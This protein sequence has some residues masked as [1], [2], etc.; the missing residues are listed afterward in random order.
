M[1]KAYDR[2]SL[3]TCAVTRRSGG[4][5]EE[6]TRD[7]LVRGHAYSIT[8]VQHIR[9]RNTVVHLVRVRNPWGDHYEW[10]GAWSDRL[11]SYYNSWQ[12]NS[13]KI[14][15]LY[16]VLLKRS[17]EWNMVDSATKAALGV[18][19]EHD[20]EF[21]MSIHD[22]QR[23][24]SRV[25]ICHISP[26][27]IDSDINKLFKKPWNKEIVEGEWIPGYSAGGCFNYSK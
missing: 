5:Y 12:K 2:S 7:G 13:I 11:V 18:T 14:K 24:F 10:N 20:G 19:H 15:V 16:L 23:Q 8:G 17:P 21:W 27:P 22:F 25:E 3:I 1:K 26:D 6:K 9:P 4:F